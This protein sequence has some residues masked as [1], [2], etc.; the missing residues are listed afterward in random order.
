MGLLDNV[1]LLLTPNAFKASKLYSVIPS[2]ATGDLAVVRNTTAT[3]VN[4]LG[5]IQVVGVNVPKLDYTSGVGSI[6]FEPQRTN[7][8]TYSNTFSD[9]SWTKV[10]STVT[11]NTTTSPDG[12]VNASTITFTGGAASITKTTVNIGTNVTISV[13]LKGTAGQTIGISVGGNNLL[14][15]LTT[16]FKRFV[17]NNPNTSNTI[18]NINTANGATARVLQ[19]YGY[20]AEV[21]SFA[22]SYIPTVASAVTRNADIISKTGI[23]SLINSQ[24]GVLFLEIA[25]LTSLPDGNKS[26]SIS[27]G[28]LNNRVQILFTS[29]NNGT[30]CNLILAGVQQAGFGTFIP[31][32]T[33]F[34]KIAFSYKLNQFKLFVNGSQ[35]E[36]TNTSGNVFSANTLNSLTFGLANSGNI[37]NAF[38]G[39]VKQLQIYKTALTNTQLID[40][41]TP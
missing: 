21:S 3:R 4:E 6:L 35:F 29:S 17:L 13:Y 12:T 19:A 32:T 22:T 20:Q 18:V 38:E 2:N 8:V 33:N 34:T 39:R 36:T 1:S 26:I 30:F 15:T 14:V 10:T 28:T 37:N 41:T 9:N 5:L 25:A 23:S 7:L 40:L 16:E 31:V 24:E 11:P 27:D